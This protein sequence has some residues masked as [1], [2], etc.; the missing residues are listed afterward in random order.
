MKLPNRR[1]LLHIAAGVTA[2][3]SLSG[4]AKAQTY[5]SRAVRWIIG[6][7][8]GG[9]TDIAARI[10]CQWLSERFN[11]PFIIEN[12]PGAA[13]NLATEA[14]VRAP[15]DGYTLL[16]VTSSNAINATLYNNL[17]YNFVRDI[18]PVSTLMRTPLVLEVHPAVPVNNPTEFIA[19]AKTNPGRLNIASFGTGTI[20]HVAIELFKMMTGTD[21]VHVPYRGSAPLVT[22]LLGGQVQGALD[23]LPASIQH[24][25]AGKFRA[26]AVTTPVRSEALPDLPTIAEFL[27]GYEATPW[28]AVGAPK[29]TPAE[30]VE[31]LNKEINA[32]LADP[33]IKA[34]LA[35]IGATPLT[36]SSS[37]CGKYVAAE[38]EK[39]AKV[40]RSANL[41]AE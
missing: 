26:L 12:R 33:K 17:A 24:I 37:E 6:F 16:Q 41:K 1:Q 10:M 39:W 15:A 8:P 5:P 36:G 32:G 35:E 30:I 23:N 29:N 19:Y 11:Q 9:T 3:P 18:A 7:P 40:I 22:D 38:T 21:I 14:V 27:P 25:R 13:T 31:R 2:L 28:N 4:R 34:R 20:S